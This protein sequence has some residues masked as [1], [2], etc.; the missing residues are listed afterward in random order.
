LLLSGLS[1][2]SLKDLMTA[3]WVTLRTASDMMAYAEE[4]D[5]LNFS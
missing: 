2:F 3:E 1:S 5:D 4:S